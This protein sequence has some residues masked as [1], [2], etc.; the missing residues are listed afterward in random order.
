MEYIYI[1][2]YSSAKL[3]GCLPF[4]IPDGNGSTV[5]RGGDGNCFIHSFPH[6][7]G[8][9]PVRFSFITAMWLSA[10]HSISDVCDV[11]ME[12]AS[13]A[14]QADRDRCPP[15][16]VTSRPQRGG[17]VAATTCCLYRSIEAACQLLAP[18]WRQWHQ[19][20]RC[21]LTIV[22]QSR[23]CSVE[24]AGVGGCQLRGGT[25]GPKWC[26]P[27]RVVIALV[28]ARLQMKTTISYEVGNMLVTKSQLHFYTFLFP[29]PTQ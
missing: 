29:I 26:N 8:D 2:L 13:L 18:Q 16:A 6:C 21:L 11:V 12:L 3:I 5:K 22:I 28:Y 19:P 10:R 27:H 1:H 4:R 9:L 24:F 17:W 7:I 14:N 23:T 25:G 15:G 20:L